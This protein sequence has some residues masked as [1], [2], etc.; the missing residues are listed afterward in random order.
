VQESVR[1]LHEAGAVDQ[2][3]MREFDM[4]CLAPLEPAK[5]RDV[6]APRGSE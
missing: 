5:P 1:H 6:V 4:M 3:T 2:V